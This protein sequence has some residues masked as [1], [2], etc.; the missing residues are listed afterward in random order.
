MILIG[1]TG[2]IG[3]GKSTIAELLHKIEPNSRAFETSEVISE[4]ATRLCQHFGQANVA[5]DN[6]AS[7]NTWLSHLPSILTAA[8]KRSVPA[9]LFVI[10]PSIIGAEAPEYV[11]LWEFIAWAH[12][13]PDRLRT[14]ITQENK[15]DY[16]PLLQ[17]IGGYCVENIDPTIWNTELIR[18]AEQAG[19]SGAKLSILGGIRFVGEAENVVKHDGLIISVIR[20]HHKTQ[21]ASDPTERQRALILPSITVHNDGSIEDLMHKVRHMYQDIL[22]GKPASMY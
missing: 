17:W 8:L 21:D 2:A 15:A 3:H 6:P 9:E 11:K 1:I 10:E 16:R 14:T 12:A 4:V 18:R 7:I 20:D 19:D 13:N 5:L 22:Q